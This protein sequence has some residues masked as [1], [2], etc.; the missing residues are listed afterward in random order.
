MKTIQLTQGK[1]ALIDDVDF[2]KVSKH[3]WNARK[4]SRKTGVW[5]AGRSEKN[6]GIQ[7]TILMHR[8]ILNLKS[9]EIID[10]LDKNG[11]NNQR[12]NLR[13][14]SH[15]QNMVNRRTWGNSKYRGV[16]K[17]TVKTTIKGR[18]ISK[19]MFSVS[20]TFNGSKKTIGHFNSEILA[21]QKYDEHAKKLHGV[22]AQLNFPQQ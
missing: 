17:I 9:G 13:K 20:I 10:H 14:C 3:K 22:F 11:L 21:A 1:V 12:N 15:S 19:R 4:C 8:Y 5:Y 16:S 2:V 6:N 18:P 7:K